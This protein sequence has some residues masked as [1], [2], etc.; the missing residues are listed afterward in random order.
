MQCKDCYWFKQ[1]KN[2]PELGNC[3][4]IGTPTLVLAEE[5]GCHAF[6]PREGTTE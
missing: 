5:E 6:R 1:Q 4:E 2:Y 3:Y